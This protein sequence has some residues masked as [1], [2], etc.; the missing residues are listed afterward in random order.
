MKKGI[1]GLILLSVASVVTAQLLLKKGMTTAGGFNPEQITPFFI[2]AILN[3][4]VLAG[5]T[6]FI[7]SAAIWLM[8]LSKAELSYA[9]PA[10]S[11][12][13]VITAIGAWLLFNENLS[14]LRIGGIII[15]CAGV[16]ALS[17]S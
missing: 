14:A 10:L 13:Y 4:Y 15:V 5:A 8:V 12:S 6:L 16:F 7:L 11:L 17:K 2:S 9:Y 1:F 3:P